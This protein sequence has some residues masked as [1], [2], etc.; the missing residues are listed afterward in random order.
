[1][2]RNWF[3][4]AFRS[5]LAAAG[6]ALFIAS[7]LFG[8][9]S[10]GKIQGRVTDEATGAPIAGAQVTVVGTTF[11]NL[12]ND[13][14]FYFINEV[15]AGL[16][17][18]RAEYIGYRA[19]EVSDER[20]LAGQTTT[21]NFQ[22]GASAVVLEAITVEGERNPLVPRDQ[23]STKSI[24]QGETID[25][26]PLD[27][28]SSIVV[29]QPGVVE[30]NRGRTIRGGRPNEE[31]VVINGVLT[32][33]FGTGTSDNIA[34]PTN[35]LEQVDVNIGAFSAE[36][37]DAQ[38]GIVS[39]VT[40]SGGP[41]FTGS[42][43]VMSD[44][45]G[46]DAWRTNF[47]R[48][49]LTLGG[50]I[51]GPLT[52]FFAGTAS[53]QDGSGTEL[54]PRHYVINGFDT[55]DI[56][57]FCDG[58]G[59]R[60]EFGEAATFSLP[61]SSSAPG[62]SDFVDVTAP[63]YVE[64]DNGRTVP[65]GW[66]QSDLFHANLNYQLPRGSRINFSF[67]R[68][69][70]Q[71]MGHSGFTS[72]FSFDGVDGGLGTRN[73]YALSWFQTISQSADQQLA[74]DFLAAFSQDRN[75]NGMLDQQ[76]WLDNM[77]PT[78]GFLTSN[79]K[80]AF[81]DANR[82]VTGFDA[83][84]PSEEFI[85]AYRSNAVPRD[86]MLLFPNR[87]DL[88]TTSQSLTGLTSNLRSNPYGMATSFNLNGAGGGGIGKSSEDRLQLRGSLDWQ[89]GRFNRIKAGAEYF[90]V[91]L[92]AFTLPLFSNG[93][94]LPESADPRKI[95]AFLQDRLDIGDLVLEAG[96]RFDYLDTDAEYP[97]IP[98]FVFNVPDSL[99]ADFVRFDGNTGTYV[100][101]FDVPCN[102]GAPTNPTGVCKSNFIAGETKS[103]FSP[104]IGAS[105]PVTPTSTF[106][107]SYGRFVQTPAFFTTS[108]FA[109]GETGVAQGNL[110]VLQDVN[111]DLTNG[112]TNSTFGRDVD[113][114][115][116]RTFEFGYRQLIGD[117]LVVDISAFNKKQKGALASRSI[118]FEDPNRAG[119]TIF[120]NVVTNA[121]FTES[122]GFEV[123]VDKSVGN[124]INSNL[125]YSF[126]DA[127]GTG[128]DP[129]FFENFILRATSN[130]SLL[131]GQPTLPPEVLLTL[132]Q[133][134]KHSLSWTGSLSF[135]T[136]F[137]EGTVAGSILKDLSLFTI[138]RVRSGLPYTKLLNQ[139]NGPIGPPSGGGLPESS[140]SGAETPWT[141]GFDLRFTKGF[142]LGGVNA[143]AFVDW[144]NPFDIES[145]STVFLETGNEVNEEFRDRSLSSTLRD[146]QL[147][148]DNNIDDFDI[149]SESTDNPFNVF[150]LLRA[151]QRFGNGDGIFT[152]EEQETAF[153][154]IYEHN[155][156]VNSRFKTSDQLMRIGL[157]IAF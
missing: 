16:Q 58:A 91:A 133:S 59:G 134:R 122:N 20:I 23:T 1:M 19:V 115:A 70:N 104:R 33:G 146:S 132:E 116:T 32:R 68:N 13:Q 12:T 84:D 102:A 66:S 26:L 145:N 149:A 15:H 43:E 42:M 139:G 54:E 135:P 50:P 118:P 93:A 95:G 151:E 67:N 64:F 79:V 144:R 126:L 110:G 141:I 157:R 5:S 82:T 113:M 99:K 10:N 98:G 62:V 88:A 28:A 105:F 89:L 24:V 81:D 35:A 27:N 76:W 87:I 114:P 18:V 129:F 71:N 123:K 77:D 29:L 147:D 96:I 140:I 37:G 156:G 6:L 155:V 142:Q 7:P 111:F 69:R 48:A 137:Q 63:T 120:F 83:F 57:S 46:P 51:A 72:N 100:P 90:A 9:E 152:V 107:L 153:G 138:L 3:R 52:F 22:L 45:L 55:C 148:G 34:L 124:M 53:G 74:F 94:P 143:Q 73:S 65:F 117:D 86:S 121:D 108:S 47:N 25:Q 119:A 136:D 11:G 112:N 127:R 85:Q 4:G 38:S 61:R 125:S 21:L 92:D 14:G 150:M 31:A 36:F 60:P 39:F 154:Q 17:T 40:R 49:E 130:L 128:S 109:V 56:A 131:T 8:Q 41:A 101:A 44:Q 97:I 80:F 30:T 78:F 106:R 2:L 103:E 75:T